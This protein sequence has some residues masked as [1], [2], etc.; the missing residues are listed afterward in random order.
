MSA[1]TLSMCPASSCAIH[2]QLLPHLQSCHR[3]VPVHS[4][5]IAQSWR[6][7]VPNHSQPRGL[8]ALVRARRVWI[9]QSPTTRAMTT[10]AAATRLR[11]CSLTASTALPCAI[12]P[13][14]ALLHELPLLLQVARA[15]D[16]VLLR[17]RA[18]VRV[19][20]K[21][22]QRQRQQLQQLQA[23]AAFK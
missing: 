22:Q 2:V 7:A 18:A 5:A 14:S 10:R 9:E 8:H 1:D 19:Q 23:A 15:A 20:K 11:N 13:R 4:Q 16:G 6:D 3:L 17:V 21:R 12:A